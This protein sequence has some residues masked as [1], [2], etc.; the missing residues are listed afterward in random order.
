MLHLAGYCMN[1]LLSNE[2]L[3]EGFRYPAAFLQM[4]SQPEL[5]DYGPWWFFA[6]QPREMQ[7]WFEMARVDYPSHLLIP[8]AKYDTYEDVACFDGTDHSGDPSI[9]IAHFEAE[10]PDPE[11]VPHFTKLPNFG[12]W[13]E[14]ATRDAEQWKTYRVGR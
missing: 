10:S 1:H 7:E 9:Y 5:P 3:P 12:A 14:E 4:M 11:A 6:A 8:F 2:D 13:I